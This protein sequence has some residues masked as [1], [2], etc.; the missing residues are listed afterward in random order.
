MIV[1]N[2]GRDFSFT[3]EIVEIMDLLK[4]TNIDTKRD[5]VV[6]TGYRPY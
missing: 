5:N 2:M 1:Y 6:T 4:E 3:I